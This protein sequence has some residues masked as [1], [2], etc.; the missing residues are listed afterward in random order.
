MKR[1]KVITVIADLHIGKKSVSAETLK[2][3]LNLYYIG[4]M[5][6]MNYLDA[7]FVAGDLL[8][9]VLSM[10]SD[11]A[12]VFLWLIDQLYTIARKRSIP[13][14]IIKGTRS[15]DNDQLNNIKHYCYNDDNV[16]F[17]VYEK[18]KS[19]S[20]FNDTYKV[21]LLPDVKVK[22]NSDI[23][24]YFN[25]KYD[26]IIGHGTISTMQFFIQE[27]ENMPTKTYIYN[28]DKL[29]SICR[30]PIIFG[31]IHQY[32]NYKNKFYY[33]GSF[34]KI[35]R[36][37]GGANG[38][39]IC[40][41]CDDDTS[42]YRV[43][44]FVNENAS[45]YFNIKLSKDIIRESNI[46]DILYYVDL[47]MKEVR[48]ND[49]VTISIDRDDD[50]ASID[51]VLM[52]D[53]RYRSDSRVSVKKKIKNKNKEEMEQVMQD[54]RDKYS[55]IMD[56]NLDVSEIMYRYYEEGYKE[57]IDIESKVEISLDAFKKLLGE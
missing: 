17:R 40:G 12:E 25:K 4:P 23:E 6:D 16:D 56:P 10:N 7:I 46:D 52:I 15:H 22:N 3:S 50:N 57:K 55:Y 38:F 44:Q 13:C 21:L 45:K 5:K 28:I 32:T 51:K 48:P 33:T 1:F 18:V 19:I 9:S 8:D 35:E 26:L 30:G 54:K 47:C 43:E 24:K 53:N 2:E 49:I 20:L 11:Y 36:G 27:S 31:H 39:L 29:M 34:D 41:I 42:K 37:S 14:I